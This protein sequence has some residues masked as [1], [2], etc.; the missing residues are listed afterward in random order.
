MCEVADIVDVLMEVHTPD[1]RRAVQDDLL[2][3]TICSEA[4]VSVK[5]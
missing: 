2:A 5:F 4:E 1:T 3:L